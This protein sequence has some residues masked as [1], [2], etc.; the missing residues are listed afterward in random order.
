[1]VHYFSTNMDINTMNKTIRCNPATPQFPQEL[2]AACCQNSILHLAERAFK[3][4]GSVKTRSLD[5]WDL[6]R[7][8]H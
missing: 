6:Q 8:S 7:L 3:I 2:G 5:N 4:S 1:M